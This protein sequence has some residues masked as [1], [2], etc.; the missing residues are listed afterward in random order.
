MLVL[1]IALVVLSMQ[2]IVFR[3]NGAYSIRDNAYTIRAAA[4]FMRRVSYTIS[5]NFCFK[6]EK[7]ASCLFQQHAPYK[8]SDNL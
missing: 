4:L 5:N 6:N 8:L 2:K 7:G 3:F 1:S